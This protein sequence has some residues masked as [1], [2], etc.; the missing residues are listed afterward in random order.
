[1]CERR[2]VIAKSVCVY[3][4]FWNPAKGLPRT[5]DFDANSNAILWLG[6]R[7]AGVEVVEKLLEQLPSAVAV[8]KLSID[9][10]PEAERCLCIL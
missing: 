10:F 1:M 7:L 9:E 6:K 2:P 3:W 4:K 5:P 8:S